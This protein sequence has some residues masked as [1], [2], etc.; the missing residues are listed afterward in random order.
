[1]CLHVAG[2]IR[3]AYMYIISKLLWWPLE[4]WCM[5]RFLHVHVLDHWLNNGIVLAWDVP[6]GQYIHVQ[7]ARPLSWWKWNVV[8]VYG[9]DDHQWK[10][11]THVLSCLWRLF[12]NSCPSMSAGSSW[13]DVFS[14]RGNQQ[15]IHREGQ[16]IE[17]STMFVWHNMDSWKHSL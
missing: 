9:G 5:V 16:W 15:S 6:V 13:K 14:G 1:M 10:P 3:I 7:V 2:Y 8:P 12:V 17:P 4:M 11:C